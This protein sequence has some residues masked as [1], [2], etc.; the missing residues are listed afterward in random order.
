MTTTEAGRARGVLLAFGRLGLTSF[1]GPVAHLGYFRDDLVGRRRWLSDGEYANLVALSQFLPGASSSQVGMAIG[2]GRAGSRGLLAAWIAFTLPSAALMLAFASG[3]SWWGT[4]M[5]WILGLKAAAAAIVLHAVIQM[6][7]HLTPDLPRIGIAVI[8][9]T[10]AL[11]VPGGWTQV[12]AVALSAGLGYLIL[13]RR[14]GPH[15]GAAERAGDGADAAAELGAIA[16]ATS[17][18]DVSA[19]THVNSEGSSAEDRDLAAPTT[20]GA[21]RDSSSFHLRV[22]RGVAWGAGALFVALFVALPLLAT[23]TGN[24]TWRLL[25]ACYRAGSL[26]F[27]G[28]HVVLPL[29]ES[30]VVPS[31]IVDHTEFL[32]GYGAAQ[33]VPGPLFSFAAYLGSVATVGPGGVIG[34]LLALVAIFL[35]SALLLIAFAPLW[36]RLR[37]QPGARRAIAG[38]SAGVVGLLAAACYDPV[39]TTGVT[40]WATA[41]IAAG[42]FALLWWGRVPVWLLVIGSAGVAALL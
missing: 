12:G 8:A 36:E 37:D 42:A 29:L 27:G 9:A 35:P 23:W 3:V 13:E 22:P 5:G 18:A 6:A 30:E 1:G 34:G 2:L 15:G 7:R 41:G 14:A 31:G 21:R 32:A 38:V 20:G 11:T 25:A 33:A 19:D 28:G 26:V 39:I 16:E 10:T 17:A 4:D 24:G 40:S